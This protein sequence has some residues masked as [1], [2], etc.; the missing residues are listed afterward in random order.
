MPCNFNDL[1]NRRFVDQVNAVCDLV[2]SVKGLAKDDKIKLMWTKSTDWNEYGFY[3]DGITTKVNIYF[4]IWYEAWEAFETP[5]F[6]AIDDTRSDTKVSENVKQ[7]VESFNNS[8]VEYKYFE[9]CSTLVLNRE[10]FEQDSVES[11]LFRI[12][13][14]LQRIIK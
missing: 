13:K 6:F 4:G 14:D 11:S 10:F 9:E 1:F 5:L 3:I 2:D 8:F 7:Y 12:L